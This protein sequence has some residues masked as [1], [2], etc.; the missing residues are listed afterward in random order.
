[1]S[2]QFNVPV[3]KGAI[4]TNVMPDSPAAAAK[5]EAGDLVVKFDGKEIHGPRDLQGGV[6]RLTAGKTYTM[7]V[8]RDGK[9]LTVQVTAKEMPKD[10]SL[11]SHSLVEERGGPQPQ[12][13]DKFGDL[14]I[15]IEAAKGD[16]LQKLGF[17]SDMTGVVVTSVA[18]E[19]PAAQAG[20]REGMVIEK[21]GSKKVTTPAEFK[22]AVH[23][24]SLEK[25]ILLL[26][27]TPRGSQ[28]VVVRK[29]V[30]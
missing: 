3:G 6:E 1:L 10:F 19:S 11:A 14:G 7:H 2:K 8:M 15:E 30:S 12:E 26:V 17:K 9:E 5:L 23:G 27:R 28:F 29:S 25:G 22:E 20:I 13:V 24:A 18:D 4:V 16:V 21:V